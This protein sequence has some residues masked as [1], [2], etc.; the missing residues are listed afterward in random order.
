MGMS[1]MKKMK[2][3]VYQKTKKQIKN[4]RQEIQYVENK[5]CQNY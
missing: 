1:V 2:C 4:F 5:Y 3:P